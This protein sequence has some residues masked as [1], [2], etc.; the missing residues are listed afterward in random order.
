MSVLTVAAVIVLAIQVIEGDPGMAV[1][2]APHD[3][4]S[5]HL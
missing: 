3:G 4:T 1:P 2:A 5:A